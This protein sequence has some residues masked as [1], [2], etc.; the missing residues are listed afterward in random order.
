MTPLIPALL[1]A[2]ALVGCTSEQALDCAMF[3]AFVTLVGALVVG[4]LLGAGIVLWSFI[5]DL[6]DSWG[7]VRRYRR[8][9]CDRRWRK[10]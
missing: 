6:G 9:F 8:Y 3:A 1:G 4:L 5:W 7:W 2:V 10:R